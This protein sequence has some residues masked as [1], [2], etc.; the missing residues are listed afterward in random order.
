ML[1]H[2]Q[3]H[4]AKCPTT[5]CLWCDRGFYFK[6][7][8][9]PYIRE[10]HRMYFFV[11]CDRT[12]HTNQNHIFLLYFL[13]LSK[14]SQAWCLCVSN[15]T[16]AN[17]I[18]R[19]KLRWKSKMRCLRLRIF[20]FLLSKTNFLSMH[21]LKLNKWWSY[22]Q[23]LYI[24]DKYIHDW[25]TFKFWFLWQEFLL[26]YYLIK[27]IFQFFLQ[28]SIFQLIYVMLIELHRRILYPKLLL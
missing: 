4:K 15:P 21:I 2:E 16:Y 7:F 3:A 8:Q 11:A 5:K 27:R 25:V 14:C 26:S 28:L 18:C 19:N 13:L 1:F 9:G 24:N 22:L 10:F 6:S 23:N 20:L 12:R 17:S